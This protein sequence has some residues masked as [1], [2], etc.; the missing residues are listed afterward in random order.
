MSVRFS[1]VMEWKRESVYVTSQLPTSPFDERIHIF[2]GMG[3]CDID[4][5]SI[6][7]C[8]SVRLSELWL[9]KYM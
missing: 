2:V 5:S 3:D 7:G 1:T 4:E 6:K 8:H 9:Y